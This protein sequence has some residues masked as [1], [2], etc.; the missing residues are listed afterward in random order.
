[1]KRGFARSQP[2][3][4]PGFAS[5]QIE[6]PP[7]LKVP[8]P[9]GKPLWTVVLVIGLIGL[10]GCM[11]WVSFASGARSFT[12]AGSLFPIVMVGGLLMMLFGGRG[13]S[14]E[15][16]RSKLDALRARF[17]LVVDELRGTTRKLA[18]RLDANYRWYHP[19]PATLEASVGTVRMWER[20]PDGSDSWFGVA[21]VGVGVT[22]L[23]EAQA[24]VFTEPQDM[25]TD[26]E[27]EPVTGKVL[28]EFVRYQTVAYG[29]PALVSLMVEPGYEL[30]GPRERVLGLVRSII[31]QLV[32]FHGPDHLRL[33]VVT[34]DVTEW[35]WVKWLP[36][37][38]DSSAEDGAGP[39]R[40]V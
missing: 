31:C 7:P 19:A 8:P 22:D 18:D 28:Q 39:V 5:T 23:V 1:V 6:L 29:T 34:S 27:L 11:V 25:P 17:L 30:R 4:A 20:K 38:G 14:K 21:R 33:V 36:H 40:M 10:V 13:G 2:A 32:F 16:S 26:I 9:E 24:A 15:M 12:G 3:E 35:D 37:V